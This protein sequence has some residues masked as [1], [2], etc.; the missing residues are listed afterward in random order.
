[1]KQLKL[2]IL[3]IVV[4]V[5]GSAWYFSHWRG[6]SNEFVEIGKPA[7]NFSLQDEKGRTVQLSDY[8]G[9]FVVLN[10]WATWCPPCVEEAGSLE[11]LNRHFGATTPDQIALL[12]VSVDSGWDPVR[13]FIKEHDIG[14]PV[15]LDSDQ[16]VP[17]SY[18]TFKYPETYIIDRQGIVRQKVIGSYKWNST[19]SM[20]YFESLLK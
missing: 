9:R 6:S 7:L 5:A 20:Q 19:E 4:I 2:F 1:M 14:F 13:Q 15:L 8:R 16:A 18:G 3:G 17:N 12:T 10:F 11:Q